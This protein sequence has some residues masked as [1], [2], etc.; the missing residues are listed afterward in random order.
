MILLSRFSLARAFSTAHTHSE[1]RG[2]LIYERNRNRNSK[3]ITVSGTWKPGGDEWVEY[4]QIKH[5]IVVILLL[6]TIVQS[7]C[8][9]EKWRK[10]WVEIFN[11]P[12]DDDFP[13]R[14][15][16]PNEC[17]VIFRSHIFLPLRE[18]CLWF[19]S[20]AIILRWVNSILMMLNM[21][22]VNLF[23]GMRREWLRRDPSGGAEYDDKALIKFK[24]TRLPK[25][26]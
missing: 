24:L 12:R 9:I 6:Y 16:H 10:V 1:H 4:L 11:L 19:K 18:A 13:P 5:Q 20:L 7:N 2:A 25:H 21:K 26:W 15:Y 17:K 8:E 23:E 14:R 3:L 22:N